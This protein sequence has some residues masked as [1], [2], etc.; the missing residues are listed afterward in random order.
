MLHRRHS[1]VNLRIT[2]MKSTVFSLPPA[3]VDRG[4]AAASSRHWNASA[5]GRHRLQS[6]RATSV[7]E[8]PSSQ[9]ET[10]NLKIAL[11]RWRAAMARAILPNP[12][13]G[14]SGSSQAS[15]T[16][17]C[18]TRD[19]SPLSTA[20]PATTTST[21]LRLTQQY[22]TTTMTLSPW[23]ATRTILCSHQVLSSPVCPSASGGVVGWRWLSHAMSR[24]AAP[25]GPSSTVSTSRTVLRN[26]VSGQQVLDL[27]ALENDDFQWCLSAQ[28]A[29]SAAEVQ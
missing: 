17:P 7:S 9:V 14:R 26:G 29:H 6:Q 22:L 27:L 16:E 10:R 4:R 23:R 8:V 15:L 24:L 18:T 20:A 21:T 5:R 11:L 1:I 25:W 13:Q 19:M 28:L 2:G 3:S 12:L